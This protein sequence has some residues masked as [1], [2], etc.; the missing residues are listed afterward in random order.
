MFS[1][2]ELHGQSPLDEHGTIELS[3]S[4]A[5]SRKP[6]WLVLL[7]LLTLAGM[8][9]IASAV[10]VPLLTRWLP[11]ANALLVTMGILLIYVGAAFFCRPKYNPDNMGWFGGMANDPFQY[12][13]NINRMLFQLHMVLGPGRFAAETLLDAWAL[14]GATKESERSAEMDVAGALADFDG[15][16]PSCYAPAEPLAHSPG[17]KADRFDQARGETERR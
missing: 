15:K 9:G 5:A 2:T 10:L 4:C 16:S 13:D 8:V 17:L 14:A 6:L 1:F 3:T 11:L 7:K 12:S